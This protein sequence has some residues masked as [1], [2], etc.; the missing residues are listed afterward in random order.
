MGEWNTVSEMLFG[1][2]QE[3]T[4]FL[5]GTAITGL[6]G[7][8]INLAGFLSIKVTSPVSHM[9]SAAVRGV[10]QTVLGV[11]LFGDILSSDRIFGICFILGGSIWY[12]YAKSQENSKPPQLLP[13]AN[14]SPAQ[15]FSPFSKS[16][17]V[18]RSY[19]PSGDSL[20]AR[21]PH[22]NNPLPVFAST[23]VE[24]DSKTKAS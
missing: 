4:T 21:S 16:P 12:T 22:D 5:Y 24:D 3:F 9:I 1:G 15:A 11:S 8:L 20:R 18:D 14:N 6:F 19:P 2:G 23:V 17:L 13:S 7:F 10:I